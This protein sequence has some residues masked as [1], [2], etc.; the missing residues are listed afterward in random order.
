MF[1]LWSHWIT[2]WKHTNN[3]SNAPYMGLCSLYGYDCKY[4]N[5]NT[6]M[7]HIKHSRECTIQWIKVTGNTRLYPTKYKKQPLVHK[8]MFHIW[9]LTDRIL[10][11]FF[12]VSWRENRL[13][14]ML[15]DSRF[16]PE[17]TEKT[18][19][20]KWDGEEKDITKQ[21]WRVCE[22]LKKIDQYMQCCFCFKYFFPSQI[23]F[24]SQRKNVWC[25]IYSYT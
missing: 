6:A 12:H 1:K 10:H 18:R 25:Y 2:F 17:F 20:Q 9:K 8:L 16:L 3:L 14:H 7:L 11:T 13:Q 24:L 21:L 4:K 19:S 23:Y 22:W 15:L 5:T